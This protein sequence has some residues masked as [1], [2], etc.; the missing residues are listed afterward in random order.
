MKANEQHKINDDCT[1]GSLILAAISAAAAS[2]SSFFVPF[3]TVIFVVAI[4]GADVD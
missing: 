3:S 2:M 1:E 4:A